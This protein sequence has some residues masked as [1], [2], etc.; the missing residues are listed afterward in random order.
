MRNS[1]QGRD[2]LLKSREQ[3]GIGTETY[4]IGTVPGVKGALPEEVT[5]LL[6]GKYRVPVTA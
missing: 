4:W 5:D 6:D 2:P 1:A 3:P